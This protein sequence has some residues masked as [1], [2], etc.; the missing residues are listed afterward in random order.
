[1]E[2]FNFKE[3]VLPTNG[4][5]FTFITSR[6]A[7]GKSELR[8]TVHEAAKIIHD[9]WLRADTCPMS[10]PGIKE[11][12]HKLLKDRKSYLEKIQRPFRVSKNSL[13]EFTKTRRMP[14]TGRE[15]SKRSTPS[16]FKKK[17]EGHELV[18][19]EVKGLLEDIFTTSPVAKGR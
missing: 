9:I 6:T 10:L 18:V 3:D 11:R 8:A 7:H 15:M 1:M 16:R 4:E 5:V 13:S 2:V 12:C 14:S 19:N 17:V